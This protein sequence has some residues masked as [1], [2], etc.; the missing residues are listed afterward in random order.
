MKY[1]TEKNISNPVTPCF[2][3]IVRDFKLLQLKQYMSKNYTHG[4]I[5]VSISVGLLLKRLMSSSG[6][7]F[8]KPLRSR[9]APYAEI[10]KSVF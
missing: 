3:A 2:S 1:R 10:Q 4:F 5:T 9:L 7:I 8:I 6:A